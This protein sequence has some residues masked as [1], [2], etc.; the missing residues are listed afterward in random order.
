VA[1]R[2]QYRRTI[3]V[4]ES[5]TLMPVRPSSEQSSESLS[6][7][8]ET[9]ITTGGV[10]ISDDVGPAAPGDSTPEETR[11]DVES[12]GEDRDAEDDD[13]VM[14]ARVAIGRN[15]PKDPTRKERERSTKSHTCHFAVGVKIA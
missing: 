15:S 5:V 10:V 2:E 6:H 13:A 3:G 4:E 1:R 11:R 7:D 9:A 8:G 14:E 12:D